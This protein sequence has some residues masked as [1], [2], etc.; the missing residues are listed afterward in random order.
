MTK[1]KVD[2]RP[3]GRPPFTG[4]DRTRLV[5]VRL[6]LWLYAQ[7]KARG[8]NVSRTLRELLKAALDKIA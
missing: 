6:P 4:D 1:P 2:P 5:H 3:R 7:I 8:S